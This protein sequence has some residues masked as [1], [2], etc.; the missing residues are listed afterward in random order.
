MAF[1]PEYKNI[2]INLLK[3][4]HDEMVVLPVNL[5]SN[6]FVVKQVLS[7]HAHPIVNNVIC[8]N[9]NAD[10]GG[11]VVL[12][13]LVVGDEN[14]YQ[15][16]EQESTFNLHIQDVDIVEN[17]KMFASASFVEISNLAP[18]E[19][20]LACNVKIKVSTSLIKQQNL[21]Y[22]KSV[23]N[24]ANQ[25]T[26]VR[27]YNNIV[28]NATQTFDITNE[29]NLPNNISNILMVNA[30]CMVERTETSADI[31]V[32]VGKVY[33][34]VI[35]LTNEEIPK[36]KHQDYVL[37]FSQELLLTG[38]TTD[39][40]ALVCLNI[41]KIE[42]EV[43][44]E[45]NSSKGVLVLK[46]TINANVQL[47]RQM[48]FENVEDAFCVDHELDITTAQYCNQTLESMQL[49]EKVEGSLSLPDDV[50]IDKIV[51]I[52]NKHTVCSIMHTQEGVQL[53]GI[54]YANIIYQLDDDSLTIGAISA[55][56]PFTKQLDITT[57]DMIV[58]T[59]ISELE[60]RS[61]RIKDI[62][63]QADVYITINYTQNVDENIIDTINIGEKCTNVNKP[64]GV[65]IINN[66]NELWDVAKHLR[67][68]PND[69]LLQNP[70]LTFPITQPTN[71][72]VYR[73]TTHTNV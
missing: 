50:R 65:Y 64:L 27:Q 22:L 53:Q 68:S 73:Q 55:E 34:Q 47:L 70:N 62:D 29:V 15:V 24:N 56:I 61:K 66:A 48:E 11:V 37:D 71:V 2:D 46:S 6:G 23:G 8:T 4:L 42:H 63:I 25:K 18:N 20:N 54:V 7:V 33:A 49:N 31:V 26:R 41:N 35:Y 16:L 13:A 38:T 51:C 9:G 52:T 57:S 58:Q 67:V 21:Q 36:L 1:A 60:A 44:G 30:D 59:T 17:I 28:N 3:N 45:M 40:R 32:A 72:L 10:V 43:Q 12:K 69:L 5:Q 14:D 39:D 19:N